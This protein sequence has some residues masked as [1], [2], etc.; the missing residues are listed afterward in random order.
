MIDNDPWDSSV[1]TVTSY[2]HDDRSSTPGGTRDFCISTFFRPALGPTQPP[3]QWTLWALLP[4]VKRLGREA[5]S[6]AFT[7]EFK[8]GGSIPPLSHT[9]S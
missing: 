8:D 7:P 5:N 9:S 1:I 4:G 3:I 6:P 2:G